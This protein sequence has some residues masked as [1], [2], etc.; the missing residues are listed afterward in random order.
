MNSLNEKPFVPAEPQPLMREIPQGEPYPVEALGPL[1]EA[2]EAVHD[3]RQAPVA[4]AGQSALAVASLAV[5]GF[6]N[7]ETLGG[8]APCSLFCLTIAES[9]ERKS[10]CDKL[11]MQALREHEAAQEMQYA[12]DMANWA[13]AHKLWTKRREKLMDAAAKT[14]SKAVEAR[15][16]LEAMPPEPPKPLSPELT[17]TDPT[18]E[19]LVKLYA[20]GR[21][22]LGLFTD[23][24]GGF[25]GGHA[26]NKDNR[27]K[28]VAGLS[29][30]WDGS[31]VNRTRA[32]DEAFTLRGRRLAAHM[33]LQ[34]VAARPL[35]SDPVAAQQGFLARFLMVQPPSAIGTR[36]RRG[37]HPSSDAALLR[38]GARLRSILET[39]LPIKEGTRQVLAPR[40]LSLSEQ[41]RELLWQFY[42]HVEKA[43]GTGG[44]LDEVRP[45]ASKAAEQA[46]RIAGVLTLWADLGAEQ[47]GLEPMAQ[48]VEL[49]QFHLHEAKR[50]AEMASVSADLERAERLRLWL[51]EDWP[52]AEVLPADVY[53]RGPPGLRNKEAAHAA[54]GTLE[55]H[56]W[57]LA[58][59]SGTVVRDK[60]RQRSFRV[61]RPAD[62]L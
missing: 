57:V 11:L 40:L 36:L 61:W 10:G 46:A 45:F 53:Q 58:L 16:D 30:L 26:M 24:A 35:L 60:P 56:G 9:G 39:D 37:H 55:Q 17:A 42:E 59:P 6:A 3:I 20:A 15:A 52:D 50:L 14:D 48:A 62:A 44:D 23:E 43:Q 29:G 13:T 31:P 7:V 32:G 34:P 18:F 5:Q 27:L 2:V 49:A 12:E 38:F 22:S 21:P 8:D 4:I 51:L 47:I 33:M 19:G 41:A 54:L 1:R 25:V 28:T